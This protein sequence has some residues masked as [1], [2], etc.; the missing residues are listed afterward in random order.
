[1]GYRK[2]L[3]ARKEKRYITPRECLRLQSFPDDFKV[4]LD[5][6]YTYKQLG[7]SVNIDN[8]KNIIET[9]LELYE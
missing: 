9:T 2:N 6:K 8:V 4:L 5:D 3:I 1:M 7:N